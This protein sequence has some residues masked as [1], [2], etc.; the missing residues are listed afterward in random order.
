MPLRQTKKSSSQTRHQKKLSSSACQI[1]QSCTPIYMKENSKRNI[2]KWLFKWPSKWR[3][4]RDLDI[5]NDQIFLGTLATV[6][7]DRFNHKGQQDD[8]KEAIKFG[9][10]A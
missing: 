3:G 8:L 7:R 9:E 4:R 6:L 5:L 2:S 10:D 1:S